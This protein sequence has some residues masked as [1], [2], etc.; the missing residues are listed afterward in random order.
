MRKLWQ[1]IKTSLTATRQGLTQKIDR[2]FKSGEKIDQ[3]SLD[4]LEEILILADLGAST[5][6]KIMDKLREKI[7]AGEVR[8]PEEVKEFLKGLITAILIKNDSEILSPSYKPQVIMVIGVNG[9]GKT[10]SIGKLAYQF[11]QEG[12]KVLLAAG[13]TFRAAGIDQLEIWAQRVGV[14]IIKHQAG[15]DPSAVIF[16]A[17][18][19]TIAKG[20][21]IM[22]ADTA[23]RQHTK[24]NL[25]EELKK[26]KRVMGKVIPEAPHEVLLVLDANTGQNAI[27]QANLFH[28]GLGITGIILTKLDGSAKG[29]IIVNIADTF[30][31]PIKYIGLGEGLEDLEIFQPDLFASAL[32]SE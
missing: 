6:Q 3:D 32:L 5:T 15:A 25:M 11:K 19:S 21:D 18:Q 1:K 26:M 30:D 2:L 27:S 23:G 8:S 24:V 13:D 16:D 10:T 20:Y 14:D 17:L 22:I 28:Q 31:I 9:V 4:E 12:K 29:G 7:K